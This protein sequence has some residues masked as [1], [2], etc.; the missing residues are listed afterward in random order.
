MNFIKLNLI[1]LFL[2]FT[3]LYEYVCKISVCV[4]T[5][6]LRDLSLTKKPIKPF[7][8]WSNKFTKT[9]FKYNI[10]NALIGYKILNLHIN[11]FCFDFDI[12]LNTKRTKKMK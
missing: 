3:H 4:L 7:N 6:K 2:F 12:K 1:L 10:M 9:N 5:I 11:K 8:N